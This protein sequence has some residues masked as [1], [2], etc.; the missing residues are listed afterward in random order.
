MT[1]EP[2]TT[3]RVPC[4]VWRPAPGYEGIY[5]VS[6]QG[7]VMRVKRGQGTR[8]GLILRQNARPNGYVSAELFR[9]GE[10]S[11]TSIHRLVAGAF[12]DNPDSLP[13]V[14]HLNSVRDDNRACNLEWTTQSLNN[15]HAANRNGAYRGERNG[16]SILTEDDVRTIRRLRKA[17]QKLTEIGERFGITKA[18]VSAIAHRRLWA[19]VE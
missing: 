2:T 17:G 11:R 15:Y 5:E 8:P 19:H 12:V 14:N 7:Q 1:T 6:D 3:K 13:I 18:H 9:D 16:R 4:E 10:G